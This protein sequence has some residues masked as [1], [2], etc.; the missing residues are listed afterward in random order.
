[1]TT[2]ELH[3]LAQDIKLWARELGFDQVGITDTDLAIEEP[4]LQA[5]LDADYHGSMDYM[6]RHGMMRAR[7]HELLPG[8]QRVLS[9]RMNYL[10]FEAGFAS[11]LRDPTLGYISRYAL[12]RD[13]HKV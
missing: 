5:W 4:R 11:T 7:P 13:Y 1:M 10:P 3:Q 8:T 12:G 2:A 9:V 6:A